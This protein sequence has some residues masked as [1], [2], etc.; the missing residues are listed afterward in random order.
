MSGQ[1]YSAGT[2]MITT[3]PNPEQ[4]F[5]MLPIL[6]AYVKMIQ[7]SPAPKMRIAPQAFVVCQLISI[8]QTPQFKSF[9]ILS[10]MALVSARFAI[11]QLDS[12]A[13]TVQN[14]N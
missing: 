8:I 5:S 11:P 6:L 9:K 12:G 14:L 7:R 4:I 1:H 2:A 13:Q 10:Q 3:S